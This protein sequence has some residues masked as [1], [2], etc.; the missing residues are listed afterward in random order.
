MKSIVHPLTRKVAPQY[1]E[2]GRS[3]ELCFY[4]KHDNQHIDVV[5]I[6]LFAKKN[7]GPIRIIRYPNLV[8]F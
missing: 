7:G 5:V 6:L 1:M 2:V 4:S 3:L 8:F